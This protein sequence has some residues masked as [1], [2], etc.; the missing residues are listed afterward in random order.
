MKKTL[1]KK[2]IKGIL[3]G[4]VVIVIVLLVVI[5]GL[6]HNEIRT[7]LT[8]KE[9]RPYVQSKADGA[10]YTIEIK[11][12]YYMDKF[13]KQE[14]VSSDRELY[15]FA[16]SNITKGLLDYDY[17]MTYTGCSSFT[18]RN[19]EG[20][21]LFA[22]NDDWRGNISTCIVFTEATK[23]RHASVSSVRLNNLAVQPSGVN[24]LLDKIKCLGAPYIP[25]DGMNDAGVACG[26]YSSYQGIGTFGTGTN[27][28]TDKPDLTWTMLLRMILD[29]ADNVEEAVEIAQNFDL[30]ESI[31]CSN[32]YMVSDASGR[33]VILEWVG[34]NSAGDNDGAKRE[35]VVTYNDEDAHIGER[36]ADSDYQWVTNF[37]VQP[38]YYEVTDTKNGYDRYEKIY[39]ELSKTNGVV[40]D[41]KAAM[42]ILDQVSY[43]GRRTIYSVVYN[44]TDKSVLWVCHENYDDETAIFEFTLD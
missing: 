39:K 29:Y 7:L 6:W 21:A 24:T 25:Y 43:V 41:E 20:D 11:G 32:H 14:G 12:D 35:L 8:L 31:N 13:L 22:R 33:S 18:A 26:V 34:S 2:V 42:D 38:D 17:F 40:K 28:D 10:V 4:I 3:L 37:I 36:E 5:G 15:E 23:E 16:I 44:L 30:H 19:E 27:L 9:I 1:W